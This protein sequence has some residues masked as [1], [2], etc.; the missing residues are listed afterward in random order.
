MAKIVSVTDTLSEPMIDAGRKLI[1]HLDAAESEI[2][3]AFWLFDSESKVW[4]LVIGSPLVATEGP[5]RYYKRIAD[6]NGVSEQDAW[7]VSLNDIGVTSTDNQLVQLIGIAVN[8]G[9][10]IAGIR[11]SR[12]AINGVYID[13]SYIYRSVH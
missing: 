4:K 7:I 13:D 12:N 6:I 2:K 8:T 9:P 10:G 1:E 3:S 11:F 5:K